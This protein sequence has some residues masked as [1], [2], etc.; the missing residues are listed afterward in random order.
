MS[1]DSKDCKY[2]NRESRL[3]FAQ[4]SPRNRKFRGTWQSRVYPMPLHDC[5]RCA[6]EPTL[7]VHADWSVHSGKRWMAQAVRRPGG[8]YLALPPAPVG[9]LDGFFAGP[10]QSWSASIFR[11][12]CPPPTRGRPASVIISGLSS[13]SKKASMRSRELLR[14][15]RLPG[16][17]ILIN[18]EAAADSSSW[19]P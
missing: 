10:A 2:I 13:G 3:A 6:S 11:S 19:M 14:R 17:S 9:A 5:A 18:R 12:V 1:Q 16:R 7:V 4:P 8:G 15:S